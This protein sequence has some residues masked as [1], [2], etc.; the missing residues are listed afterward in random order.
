MAPPTHLP[1]KGAERERESGDV[2]DAVPAFP[3]DSLICKCEKVTVA[4]ARVAIRGLIRQIHLSHE[5]TGLPIPLGPK[6]RV[7]IDANALK[8]TRLRMGLGACKG[9][10]CGRHLPDLVWEEG[11]EMVPYTLRPLTVKSNRI[12]VLAESH[13]EDVCLSNRMTT[14]DVELSTGFMSDPLRFQSTLYTTGPR[15][16][17]HTPDADSTV[18]VDQLE[19]VDTD[20]LILGAGSAG[21][22][23]AVACARR[24]M[25]L[26]AAGAIPLRVTLLDTRAASGQ[27]DQKHA[28]GGV[29][30]AMSDPETV[31]LV[32]ESQKHLSTWNTNL[33]PHETETEA[34]IGWARSGYIF[35][36]YGEEQKATLEKVIRT[37]KSNAA[38]GL[39]PETGLVWVDTETIVSLV[40]GI[41]TEGLLGGAYSP[42]D[43]VASPIRWA[44][45]ATNRA[46]GDPSLTHC[47]LV[48]CAH[49]VRV[50]DSE[51]EGEGERC[52]VLVRLKR[53]DEQDIY[54]VIRAQCVIEALGGAANIVQE[55]SGL[56]L[57]QIFPDSH[58]AFVTSKIKDAP[59]LLQGQ[60]AG[61]VVID[62]RPSC[63]FGSVYWYI[64]PEGQI[65]MCGTPSPPQP[66]LDDAGSSTH[67]PELCQRLTNQTPYA[68]ALRV[69]RRWRGVYPNTPDGKPIVGPDPENPRLF[70]VNGLAGHGFML[71]L[72]LGRLVCDAVYAQI[73]AEDT[74]KTFGE[75]E[76]ERIL[77]AMRVNRNYTGKELLK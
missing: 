13:S 23:T 9:A 3:D 55:R 28:I 30:S 45:S 69:H 72:G 71:S 50:L 70:H 73:G 77:T 8:G 53:R 21:L 14:P 44:V 35:T 24:N 38:L 67:L 2:E 39:H 68:S 66:G 12:G 41:N 29:R 74:G 48:T 49:V 16:Y 76:R 18:R 7:L 6:G 65:I 62:L 47:S 11:A 32:S 17:T 43:G 64:T 31:L 27:G 20:V 15:M 5:T 37:Q 4:D 26:E 51:G 33:L 40:P 75:G 61:P 57:L 36:A 56:G 58:D 46:V 60:R 54:Q 1:T 52:R 34:D 59:S 19:V 10:W 63:S 25:A 22:G 42:R